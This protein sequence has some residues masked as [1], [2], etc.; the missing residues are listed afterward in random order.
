MC[1][2]CVWFLQ[3]IF[4]MPSHICTFWNVNYVYIQRGRE[5]GIERERCLSLSIHPI[6]ILSIYERCTII[7]ITSYF[8]HIWLRYTVYSNGVA[9]T[10]YYYLDSIIQS[11]N[12]QNSVLF[13]RVFFTSSRNYRVNGN[14]SCKW[15]IWYLKLMQEFSDLSAPCRDRQILG[16]K[17]AN[18][19]RFFQMQQVALGKKIKLKKTSLSK[20]SDDKW[21]SQTIPDPLVTAIQPSVI[22]SPNCMQPGLI[23]QK[24]N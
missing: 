17:Y 9:I 19:S 14:F 18:W 11:A 15:S 12:Q 4:W 24:I 6:K 10:F 20:T 22:I 5:P 13:S 7:K 3:L 8:V 23:G 1:V 16:W 21:I 2:L